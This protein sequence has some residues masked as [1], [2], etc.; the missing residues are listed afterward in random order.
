MKFR[1]GL[2]LACLS[3]AMLPVATLSGPAA[4]QAPP[5][6]I[7][8]AGAPDEGPLV[9]PGEAPDLALFSTGGVVGYV[10]PCG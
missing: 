10:E 1:A 2:W 4:R 8:P 6:K 9:A 7:A 5:E 3:I